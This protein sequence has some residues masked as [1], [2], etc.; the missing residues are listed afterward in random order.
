MKKIS[1]FFSLLLLIT[2][3]CNESVNEPYNNNFSDYF[4]NSEGNYY[5]YNVTVL[6][7]NGSIIQSGLKKSHYFG[8]TI[9]FSIKNQ[10]KVDSF[11]LGSLQNINN[12]YFRKDAYGV[13]NSVNVDTN[14]F[15]FLLPDSLRGGVSFPLQYP[16][17]LNSL[18]VEQKWDLFEVWFDVLPFAFRV[19]NVEAEIVSLDTFFIPNQSTTRFTEAYEIKYTASLTTNLNQSPE[20]FEVNAWFA[21]G[22]GPVKWE[23]DSEL[24]NF[25]AGA[26]IYP[27]NTTVLEELE[28]F[29][30]N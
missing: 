12:S 27:I 18:E 8:D 3:S 29:K 7:T 14:G 10:I 15:Y 21:K 9:I 6:D 16:I 2:C 17:I 28:S 25:F 22:I 19:F 24:I 30:V 26:E 4:P 23:G 20:L 11:Q 5:Y 13:L 1:I